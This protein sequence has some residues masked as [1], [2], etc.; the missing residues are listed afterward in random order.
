MVE[1]PVFGG[2]VRLDQ[3]LN[4]EPN[5]A[6]SWVVSDSGKVYTFTLQ[7]GLK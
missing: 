7:P 3:H 1:E 2:L 5:A 6:K 4:V